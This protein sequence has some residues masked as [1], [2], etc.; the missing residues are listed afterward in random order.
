M[1]RI[2]VT[3][4]VTQNTSRPGVSAI[5]RRAT[6]HEGYTR[7][8][9]ARRG[10]EKVFAWIKQW[11]GLRQFKLR[12]TV[13]VSAVL[14]QPNLPGQSDPSGGDGGGISSRFQR[15]SQAAPIRQPKRGKTSEI[16]QPKPLIH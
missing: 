1:H 12:G 8:L 6:R 3:P 10:I 2:R 13:K 9:S 5:H 7:S 15:C 11:G 4:H 16:C 14:Q